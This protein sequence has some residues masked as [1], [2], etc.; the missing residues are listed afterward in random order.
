MCAS[1]CYGVSMRRAPVH[2]IIYDNHPQTVIN[3]TQAYSLLSSQLKMTREL[4]AQQRDLPVPL[5]DEDRA[6]EASRAD[7]IAEEDHQRLTDFAMASFMARHHRV[8]W[9]ELNLSAEISLVDVLETADFDAAGINTEFVYSSVKPTGQPSPVDLWEAHNKTAS[10]SR[11]RV[12][13]LPKLV[14]GVVQIGDGWSVSYFT[15][16]VA[17]QIA[18]REEWELVFIAP[19]EAGEL[20]HMLAR[21]RGWLS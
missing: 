18:G 20:G 5:D 19:F 4:Q 3:A 2:T 13:I 12:T 1:V 8:T 15:R 9:E 14:D 11:Y 17:D 16:T 10:Q 21:I 7:K 6:F